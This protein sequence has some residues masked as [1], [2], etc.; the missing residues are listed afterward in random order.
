MFRLN[1][2]GYKIWQDIRVD[3]ILSQRLYISGHN[4]SINRFFYNINRYKSYIDFVLKFM[5]P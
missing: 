2:R 3:G 5:P 1:Y 4:I